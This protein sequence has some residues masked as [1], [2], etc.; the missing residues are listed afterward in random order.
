MRILYLTQWFEPEPAFKG[1]Q[2]AQRLATQ[3]N[4]V[5]VA[6]GFP[7]YP[8]GKLYAGHRLRPYVRTT[9]AD[10]L[11]LHRLWLYPSHDRSA[12]GRALNYISFFLSCLVFLLVKGGRYDAVYVY[13]PP[14]T[15]SLAAV[16]A[17]KLY[18]FRI[19]MDVQDLWPDSVAASGMASSAVSKFL[20]KLCRFVYRGVDQIIAQTDG[21]R[22]RII[23]RGVPAAKVT[24]IYNW[25]TYRERDTQPRIRPETFADH[26]NLVYGGN[27][28]QA[29]ALMHVVAAAQEAARAFPKL[30]LHIFGSGI[31]RDVL[32]HHLRDRSDSN[33][34][35]H[36]PVDRHDMDRIFDEADI[37]IMHLRRDPLYEFTMPSKAQH[38]LACGKPIVAG[39]EGETARILSSS[40]AAL[41]SPPEDAERMARSIV[42]FCSLHPSERE[43]LGKKAREFYLANFDMKNA[44]ACTQRVLCSATTNERSFDATAKAPPVE[45]QR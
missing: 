21:M 42:E 29:Q 31:E 7:N 28:G 33:L 36:A 30:R 14:L 12:I 27:V 16:L 20:S 6:T 9:T 19:V 2:F 34:V 41:V 4:D 10:G 22:A 3:G 45:R 44:I 23:E 39:I 26:V 25:A 13:H 43:A 35:L 37:L 8:G 1:Q 18:R 17:A 40:G 32:M 15:P 5:E 38:Y 24:R 11:T